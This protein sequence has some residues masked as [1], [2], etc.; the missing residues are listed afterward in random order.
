MGSQKTGN[1]FKR[2]LLIAAVVS[3][4]SS[5]VAWANPTGASVARGS[6][7]ISTSG[8]T[9]T[10]TNTPKAIINW[11]S[12]GIAAGETVK[13]VQ[14]SARSSVLNRVIGSDPS[15]ILGALQS[16]GKV[17]LINPNGIMFGASARV[18]VNGLVASTLNMSD[19]DFLNDRMRFT[20][21]RATPGSVSNAGNINT[22]TGGFVYIV[23]PQV[24]NSGVISTPSGEAILAAGHSVELVDS[25]DPNLRVVVNA[26]KQDVNLSQIMTQSGG[27]IY[28]VLN[29]GKVSANTAVVG[30]TGRVYLKSAGNIQTTATSVIEA[31]GDATKDG[32]HIQAFADQ[33]G[34]YR[35][36]FDASG[37]NGGF[38]ETSGH[39]VDIGGVHVKANAIDPSGKPGTWLLDPT[40]FVIDYLS[41]QSIEQSIGLYGTDSHVDA[42]HDITV[43]YSINSASFY[44]G[45]GEGKLWLDA[46]NDIFVDR[47][48]N[49]AGALDM[50][51]GNNIIFGGG[52]YPHSQGAYTQIMAAQ[53]TA[54][55]GGTFGMYAG[56]PD[57]CGAPAIAAIGTLSTQA[58]VDIQAKTINLVGYN[59]GYSNNPVVIS[60]YGVNGGIIQLNAKNN[61]TLNNATLVASSSSNI[62]GVSINAP[63][64]DIVNGSY[65]HAKSDSSTAIAFVD[66]I[67]TNISI[68]GSS[69]IFAD[70][71]FGGGAE[72]YIDA[73]GSLSVTGNAEIAALTDYSAPALVDMYANSMLIDSSFVHA[74]SGYYSSTPSYNGSVLLVAQDMNLNN[75]SISGDYIGLNYEPGFIQTK[76][77]EFNNFIS[78]ATVNITN[79]YIYGYG[80]G[81]AGNNVTIT[82]SSL[83]SDLMHGI[84]TNDMKLSGSGEGYSLL[85]YSEMLLEVGGHLY[86]DNGA[87]IVVDSPSTLY[88][89]FPLLASDG[90]LVDGVANLYQ[91]SNG[92]FLQVAGA[93]PILG[94][95]FFVTYGV[96]GSGSGSGSLSET[97]GVLNPIL[98]PENPWLGDLM[99]LNHDEEEDKDKPQQC[100]A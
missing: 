36:T 18:D 79:S 11:A 22:P 39:T 98:D 7:S 99:N 84:A 94:S 97:E 50:K 53:V 52:G 87:A 56:C 24:E 40:D 71:Y 82:N 34:L 75:S 81:F 96:V 42:T 2:K 1:N 63:S 74:S 3:C 62:A 67:G 80:I 14:Q 12:F 60:A 85:A 29:S 35:G 16:N 46:G 27:N 13:F 31:R 72:V 73:A 26:P 55:A 4:F 45:P 37:R 66:V 65:I 33:D 28:N 61:V 68:S 9:M 89:N 76:T 19:A 78:T 100:S 77:A 30:E 6:A 59:S 51:A 32:G 88:F 83:T 38:I 17:F 21:D 70:G 23:A 95:N 5:E 92:S 86:L 10:V 25:T 8:S 58:M 93:D 15:N 91:G 57:S 47:S 64:I 69:Q 48:I 49:I 41:A 43:G 44:G 54:N 20:A 90:W